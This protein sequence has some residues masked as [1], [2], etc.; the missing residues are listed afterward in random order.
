MNL[1]FKSLSYLLILGFSGWFGTALLAQPESGLN[2]DASPDTVT[3]GAATGV[4]PAKPVQAKP[5]PQQQPAP[6]IESAQRTPIET[7]RPVPLR[8]NHQPR[9]A[10]ATRRQP[11][12]PSRTAEI[13][14][15]TD[16]ARITRISQEGIAKE[17]PDFYQDLIPGY[18]RKP[19]ELLHDENEPAP[20]TNEVE[21]PDPDQ[22]STPEEDPEESDGR[23]ILDRISTWLGKFDMSQGVVNTLLL[24]LI[25]VVFVLYRMRGGRNRR[26]F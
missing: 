10:K 5:A 4:Q 24:I 17:I 19:V 8:S 11:E 3:P 22:N 18:E 14:A 26:N 2:T 23:S 9:P 1:Q 15:S 25:V 12:A 21:I 16:E 20:Q 7:V 13:P 6:V